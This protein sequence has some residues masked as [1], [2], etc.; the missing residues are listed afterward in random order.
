[1]HVE[2]LLKHAQCIILSSVNTLEMVM[3]IQI[4]DFGCKFI[5]IV[6]WV[7]AGTVE[8]FHVDILAVFGLQCRWVPIW[9]SFDSVILSLLQND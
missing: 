6:L 5:Q 4:E 8:T 7:L 1:M 3:G 9:L 2:A